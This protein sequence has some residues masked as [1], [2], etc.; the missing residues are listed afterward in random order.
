[1][2]TQV[3]S[4]ET[5]LPQPQPPPASAEQASLTD[6]SNPTATQPNLVPDGFSESPRGPL[7]VIRTPW[8]K[9]L[10]KPL[11]LWAFLGSSVAIILVFVVLLVTASDC[12]AVAVRVGIV[13]GILALMLFPVT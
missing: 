8:Y 3:D 6:A 2:H 9:A 10:P 7:P 12:A 4:N 1:M 13:S 11:P 5:R